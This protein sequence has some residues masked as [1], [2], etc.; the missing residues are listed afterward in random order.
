[1]CLQEEVRVYNDVM[2]SLERWKNQDV[3]SIQCDVEL[4]DVGSV[5]FDVS[6]GH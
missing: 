2:Q 6:F 5:R 4:I 1:M 3:P